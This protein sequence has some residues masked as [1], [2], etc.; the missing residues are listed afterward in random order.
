MTTFNRR[1]ILQHSGALGLGAAFIPALASVVKAAE[2]PTATKPPS[3]IV[4]E[5]IEAGGLS[6]YSYF[7]GDKNAGVA[8][9][10]DPRRDVQ[11]YLDLAKQHGM[12]ITHAIETHVHA[13]F[14][15]GSRQLAKQSGTAKIAA[16]IEG[17]PG[18]A[19]EIDRPLRDG[20]EVKVGSIRLRGI[21]TPGHTPEHMSYLASSGGEGWALFTGD[22]LFVGSVGR[23]DL[24]GVQNTDT[25]AKALYHSV[26]NAFTQLPGELQIYPAHGPGSPCGAGIK[27]PEGDPT[28][29]QERKGNPYWRMKDE[30]VFIEALLEAQPPVPYYWPRM[31]EINVAGPEILSE[32]RQPELV[33]PDKFEQLVHS[34]EV[35][36]LDTRSM[37]SFAGGHIRGAMNIGYNEVISMWGG[38]MLDP[39]KPIAMLK[40]AQGNFKDPVDWLA[41]VGLTNV[42]TGLKGDMKAWVNSG[43]A[44]DSYPT[45]T[46]HEVHERFPS[47]EMTLLDVRQPAEWD[48]GHLPGAQYLFLPEIPEKLD[49]VDKS[50]PVVV[51]CGNGYRASLGTSVL[52]AHGFDARSVPGSWDAW[53]AAGYNSVKPERPG[54]ASETTRTA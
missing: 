15:S 17:D 51:Y 46:V 6:H 12:K 53:V 39:D 27:A 49:Q 45:M 26:Q 11:V 43:R 25:L 40:P 19:F 9:V 8:V 30:D 10:I 29:A 32:D 31:K 48:M 7:L 34:G 20:D 22:F 24:M 16:S 52:R 4:L 18:Y 36:L 23:P 13:D 33:K 21:H 41:R 42:T 14:V 35:Q 28:L 47:D 2:K 5:T 38:W 37:H 54:K 50:K 44:F 3:N 1:E